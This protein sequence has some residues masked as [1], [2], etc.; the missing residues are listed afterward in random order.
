[1][2]FTSGD[3]D[4]AKIARATGG[5]AGVDFENIRLRM[6]ERKR[7]DREKLKAQRI[8]VRSLRAGSGGVFESDVS[9]KLGGTQESL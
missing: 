5:I 1:M 8:L 6:E 3:S 7:L 2:G 9:S 4:A